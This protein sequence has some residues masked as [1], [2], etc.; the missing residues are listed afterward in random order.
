MRQ[1][2]QQEPRWGGQKLRGGR[3]QFDQRWGTTWAALGGDATG[4]QHP[5]PW[6]LSKGLDLDSMQGRE[7]WWEGK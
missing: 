3:A 1:R 7:C 2:A 4:K 5:E 6:I